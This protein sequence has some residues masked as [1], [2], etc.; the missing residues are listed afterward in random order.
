MIAEKGHDLPPPSCPLPSSCNFALPPHEIRGMMR[1]K[2]NSRRNRLS[3][4][5]FA[6][7][8]SSEPG[9]ASR[10]LRDQPAPLRSLSSKRSRLISSSASDTLLLPKI[11]YSFIHLHYHLHYSLQNTEFALEC[12]TSNSPYFSACKKSLQLREGWEDGSRAKACQFPL[13]RLPS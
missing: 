12:S 10:N 13:L 2:S 11:C 8:L 6:G 5:S 9:S 7:G 3:Y 1:I 4:R